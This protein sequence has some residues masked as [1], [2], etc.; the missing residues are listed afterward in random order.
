MKNS[1]GRLRKKVSKIPK[2]IRLFLGAVA[3]IGFS[4]A[5][6][7]SVFN[8]FLN[9]TF[10]ISSLQRSIL[11]LPRELPGFLVV[12]VSAFLFFMCS[13]R[14]AVL[15]LL[16]QGLGLILIGS[17]SPQLSF[18]LAWLFIFSLGQHIFLPLNFSIGMGLAREGAV[19][20]RLG[21][22]SGVTNF[23][24]ILGSFT[25]F[26][27]FS[28]FRFNFTTAFL[29]AA[30]VSFC[31]AGLL[32]FMKPDK[33][34]H[35]KVRLKLHKEYRLFYWL[36]ILYGTRKQIFLTFAPWVLVTVFK[37]PTR[38]LAT[39]LTITGVIGIGFQPILGRAIDRLGEKAV[40]ATEAVVLIFVCLGY[41]FSKIM[42]HGQAAFLAA[43]LCFILD[44]MLISVSMAR[45]TYLKKIAVDPEHVTPTLSMA[46]TIDHL[47]SISVA[48][49]SGVIWFK[50][51]YQYV[52]VFGALIA[53]ANFF[54][55]LKIKIPPG[56]I[57]GRDRAP[58]DLALGAD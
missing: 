44:G 52:F 36:N 7:N 35:L 1:S 54:S 42:F 40:L 30:G 24:A 45:A 38:I 28:Y 51:G 26:L 31:A 49:L 46:T 34:Q 12:F 27:G 4:Q 32:F 6:Y 37:A 56:A 16:L 18:M 58:A 15:A 55:V 8:N 57:K 19:G 13:R 5:V 43:S 11:E 22:F 17:F 50:L 14:L 29:L 33:P 21:Q 47:F 10:G 20:K 41:G 3:L 25:V 23:A 2:D 9:D 53:V 39:L 48:L